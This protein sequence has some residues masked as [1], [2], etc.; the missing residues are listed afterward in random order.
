MRYIDRLGFQQ[1][2]VPAQYEM[3]WNLRAGT[4]EE[5]SDQCL[6]LLAK[7]LA[8]RIS[9]APVASQITHRE[10]F[11]PAERANRLSRLKG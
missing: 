1:D 3:F 5:Q 7:L 8:G 2:D 4:L 6:Q 11:S 10:P 9:D